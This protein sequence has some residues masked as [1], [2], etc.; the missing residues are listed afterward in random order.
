MVYWHDNDMGAW[1][2][3]LMTISIVLFWVLLVAGI[4]ALVRYLGRGTPNDSFPRP[5]RRA[6]EQILAER[7]AHGEIDA[8]EYRR[9]LDTLRAP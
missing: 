8:D 3:T 9:R 1:G 6:P 5:E 7:F 2:V 4:V